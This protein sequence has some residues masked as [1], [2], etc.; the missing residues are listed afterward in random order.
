MKPPPTKEKGAEREKPSALYC[1]CCSAVSTNYG[2]SLGAASGI[3]AEIQQ[4]IS[5]PWL[6]HHHNLPS[7]PKPD[8]CCCSPF[9][10]GLQHSR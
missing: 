3:C 6:W 5:V 7:D 9:Y 1:S 4:R 10:E 2:H 8:G